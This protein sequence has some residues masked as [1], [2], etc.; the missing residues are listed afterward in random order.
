[1]GEGEVNRVRLG[2][3]EQEER[4]RG[5]KGREGKRGEKMRGEKERGKKVGRRIVVAF[6]PAFFFSFFPFLSFSFLPFSSLL[7]PLPSPF[8]SVLGELSS[9]LSFS[10]SS[11]LFSLISLLSCLLPLSIDT[12][13][14]SCRVDFLDLT[15]YVVSTEILTICTKVPAA[16]AHRCDSSHLHV[17]VRTQLRADWKYFSSEEKLCRMCFAQL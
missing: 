17:P 9:L 10:L 5:G 8:L 12:V 4:K 2:E 14:F 1:M 11:F 7:L 13:Q 6:S 3:G 15:L 16:A